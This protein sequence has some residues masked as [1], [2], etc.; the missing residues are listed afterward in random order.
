MGTNR[1]NHVAYD[2]YWLF[3]IVLRI[4]GGLRYGKPRYYHR[5]GLGCAR[6][7]IAAQVNQSWYR[8]QR[9]RSPIKLWDYASQ[10]S[11]MEIHTIDR[12]KWVSEMKSRQAEITTLEHDPR[13][14]NRFLSAKIWPNLNPITAI[15]SIYQETCL[16]GWTERIATTT[17]ESQSDR[18]WAIGQRLSPNCCQLW[19]TSFN[20]ML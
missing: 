9:P 13:S 11:N 18:F 4:S 15:A 10:C 20:H 19:A 2:W 17:M 8:H 12:A 14:A 3:G 5:C 6:P 1:Q 7:T 16:L